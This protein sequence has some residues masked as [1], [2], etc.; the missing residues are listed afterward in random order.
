MT[1]ERP[2][3]V[4]VADSLAYAAAREAAVVAVNNMLLQQNDRLLKRA[5]EAE[6]TVERVR[7]VLRELVSAMALFDANADA[8]RQHWETALAAARAE[9]GEKT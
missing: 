1:R 5:N 9:L 4:T 2:L 6:K 3:Y 7:G 8:Y